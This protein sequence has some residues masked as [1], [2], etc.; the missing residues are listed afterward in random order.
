MRAASIRSPDV[1]G[2]RLNAQGR[3]TEYEHLRAA[4]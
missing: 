3:V 2:L 1:V 4:F